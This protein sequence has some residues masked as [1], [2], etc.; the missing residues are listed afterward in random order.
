MVFLRLESGDQL[1]EPNDIEDTPEIV[2]E[3][4]QAELAAHLLQPSHQKST[5]VHP[6]LDRAKRVFDRLSALVED[7]GTLRYAGLHSIQYGLVLEAR[8]GT[9]LIAGALRPD[10]T[11]SASLAVA[12]IDL[13]QA[14]HQR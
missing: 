8:Y 12:V 9:E 5:L 2:G 4:G 1:W 11:V 10:R 3:R 7:V 14:T 13:F 6:L